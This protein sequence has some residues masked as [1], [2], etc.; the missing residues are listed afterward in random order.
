MAQPQP[1]ESPGGHSRCHGSRE[2]D[3]ILWALPFGLGLGMQGWGAAPVVVLA[4]LGPVAGR[5]GADMNHVLPVLPHSQLSGP[6]PVIC[7][8]RMRE[9][10]IPSVEFL[11]AGAEQEDANNMSPDDQPGLGDMTLPPQGDGVNTNL[12]FMISQFPDEWVFLCVDIDIVHTPS[13][14]LPAPKIF[15]VYWRW[16]NAPSSPRWVAIP[17]D[18]KA[19]RCFIICV[20]RMGDS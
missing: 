12:A 10:V 19:V 1:T 8:A 4:I 5:H 2:L 17:W 13:T 20:S 18:T 9:V 3:S 11:R 6:A 7:R 14:W 16:C 15:A